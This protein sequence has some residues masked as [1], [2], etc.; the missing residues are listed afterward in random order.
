MTTLRF[1]LQHR[2]LHNDSATYREYLQ[3]LADRAD[4]RFDGSRPWDM[5]IHDERLWHR[6]VSDGSLGLGEAYMDGWWDCAALDDFF[7]HVLR[8]GIEREVRSLGSIQLMLKAQLQNLQ[9]PRRATDVAHRHYDLSLDLYRSMLDKQLIYSCGYW[10]TATDLDMAQEAKL[11]LICRKLALEP[12]MRILDIG[13]GWGG[14]A[15]YAAE[16]YGV[17]VKGITISEEQAHIAR[18]TCAGLPVDIE[19]QDYRSL[20]GKYDRIMSIGMF[21]HVGYKNYRTYFEKARELLKPD[22]LFLLH[23]IGSNTSRRITDAWI[24]KYIFPNSMLPSAAQ[25]TQALENRFVIEDWHNFGPD[26]DKT[27]MCWHA[28]FERQWTS[29]SGSFDERFRRMW[30]YYLLSSAATFRVRSS[31]LWQVLLSPRGIPG[32]WKTVR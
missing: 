25:I 6:I 15:R 3:R 5:K 27:L 28:N 7:T 17:T 10:N 13:C 21:E 1:A 16:T 29:L 9:T 31:Q 20:S 2:F 8:S 26:Y 22:G 30:N 4:V 19:V 23:T 12:G 24:E 11:S 18:Q 14:A 32:G